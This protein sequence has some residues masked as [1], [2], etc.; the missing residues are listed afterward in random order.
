MKFQ[1]AEEE[2]YWLALAHAP[3][4][5]PVN[6]IRLLKRFGT[7]RK[8]FEAGKAEWQFFGLKG[9]LLNFLQNPDW[10][11]VEKD[12]QW[13][14]SSGC[15]LLTLHHPDYPERLRNIH[16]PPPILFVLG[17][18]TLLSSLQLGMVGTRSPSHQ[19]EE[20]ARE[21]AHYLSCAGFTIT[22]GLALGIDAASHRG[23]LTGSGKTIA[24]TGTGLDRVYPAQH[25]ELAHQIAERGALVSEFF[26]GTLA[27]P[28]HF[29][30]RNRI[31]SGLSLGILV[32]EAPLHSGALYTAHQALEQ[33]R[34]VFAIPGHIHNPLVKGCHKLIKDGA[35][36]VENAADIIEELLTHLPTLTVQPMSGESTYSQRT[37]SSP[38]QLPELMDD[39]LEPEYVQLLSLLGTKPTSI[40]NLVELSGL[41]AEVISSML[42]ILE[43]RGLVAAQTGGLYIRQR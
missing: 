19:G 33:G 21:F 35:K 14:D 39:E 31:I 5:G 28:T 26:P 37:S 13:L 43:L 7:P 29:P 3:G 25:R 6:F 41:T 18:R 30:R 36:L 10:Y 22:S 1:W 38:S 11:V 4:I 16:D 2:E 42:L 34:E 15:Q 24:V 40:D 8:V 12:L 17:E 23:A 32:V 20:V 9:E 27:K